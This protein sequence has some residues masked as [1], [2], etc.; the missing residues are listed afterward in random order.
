MNVSTIT[1]WLAYLLF[2]SDAFFSKCNQIEQIFSFRVGCWHTAA[3]Q[4]RQK[5]LL[6][7]THNTAPTEEQCHIANVLV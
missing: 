5:F 2:A 6:Y 4:S 1:V 7:H 3:L